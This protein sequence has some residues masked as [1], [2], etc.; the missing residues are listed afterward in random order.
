MSIHINGMWILV[1]EEALNEWA[2]KFFPHLPLA[3]A[4]SCII[5]VLA[6]RPIKK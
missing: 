4:R 5:A 6:Y 2:S 1:T 3:H